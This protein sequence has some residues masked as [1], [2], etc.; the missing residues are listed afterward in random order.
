MVLPGVFGSGDNDVAE[1]VRTARRRLKVLDTLTISPISGFEF[2][3]GRL[4]ATEIDLAAGNLASAA[5]RAETLAGLPFYRDKDHLA[6]CRRLFVG[7]LAGLDEV[8]RTG[9]RFRTGRERTGRPVAAISPGAPTPLRWCMAC[10]ATRTA[11][12]PGSA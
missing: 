7:A 4:M 12:R 11:G 5:A 8:A 9:E 6:T 3:D 10:A 1:A 2:G